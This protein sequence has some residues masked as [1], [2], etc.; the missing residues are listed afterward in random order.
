MADEAQTFKTFIF[1][2]HST[3]HKS[4]IPP[5]P[6]IVYPRN[7]AMRFFK[8]DKACKEIFAILSSFLKDLLQSEDLVQG[9]ATWTKTTLAILQL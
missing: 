2:V 6:S 4:H 8:I 1:L 5:K 7:L 3:D 9:A